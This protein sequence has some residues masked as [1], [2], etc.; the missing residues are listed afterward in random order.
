MLRLSHEGLS[1]PK[2]A[3]LLGVS[4]QTDLH[5]IQRYELS[6]NLSEVENTLK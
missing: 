4:R 5:Q 2:I 1:A 6:K 3:T